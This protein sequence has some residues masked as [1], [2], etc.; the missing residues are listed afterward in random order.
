M[1]QTRRRLR[2]VLWLLFFFVVLAFLAY[3]FYSKEEFRNFEWDKFAAA[4]RQAD[5]LYLAVSV[6]I[7]FLTYVIRTWRWQ[8][9]SRPAKA[10]QFAPVLSA[11][12]VGFSAVMLLGRAGEIVRPVMIGRKEAVPVSSMMA[13]WAVE[14]IFDMLTMVVLLAWVLVFSPTALVAN[15]ANSH[16]VRVVRQTGLVATLGALTGAALLWIYR[17]KPARL[18]GLSRWLHRFLP[19]RW[20]GD[21]DRTLG[22]FGDGLKF[23][24]RPRELA[25]SIFYSFGLWFVICL[26]YW[27]ICQSLGGQMA[28]LPATAVVILVFFAMAGS[29]V[30]VPGVGGGFQAAT[31]IALTALYRVEVEMAASAAILL[32]VITFCVVLLIGIPLLIHEGWSL[33]QLRQIAREQDSANQTLVEKEDLDAKVGTAP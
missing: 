20:H 1:I 33:G 22:S 23:L 32:W 4:F 31:F 10:L 15:G 11:T 24:R 13:V 12:I 25:V 16:A 18:V 17:S 27:L 3:Q 8:C 29:A 5:K 26:A 9:F 2:V 21:V 14:R 30:Q 28:R 7:I 6:L 19:T